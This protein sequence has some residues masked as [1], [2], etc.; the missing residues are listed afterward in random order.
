MATGPVVSSY[1]AYKGTLAALAVNAFT[2]CELKRAGPVGMTSQPRFVIH[3][4]VPNNNGQYDAYNQAF[5][6]CI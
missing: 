5:S 6:A 4:Q 1:A 2:A 3:L